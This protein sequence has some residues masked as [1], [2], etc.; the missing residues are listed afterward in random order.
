MDIVIPIVFPEYKIA[1][2]IP[3]IEVDVLPWFEF[4]NF[5]IPKQKE[6]FSNLGHAGVLFINGKNGVTKYY[7]YGRYDR[8]A[9]GLVRRVPIPNAR[10]INSK[11][12]IASLKG[13][14]R[15]IS[16]VAGQSSRIEGAYIEA[17]DNFTEMLRYAENRKLQNLNPNRKPYD[18]TSNSCIHFTKGVTAKAGVATPWMIDPR[19]NSYI[20]EF[21][22]DFTDLDYR[23]ITNKLKIEALGTF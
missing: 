9:I 5:T 12:D 4:D 7:E 1:V 3:K 21:R 22:D 13:P 14:L 23:F 10:V 11:L 16:R 6:K 8:A 17:K 19:P 18:L 15:K 2:K 20:G